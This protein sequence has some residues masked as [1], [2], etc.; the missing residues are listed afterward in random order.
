MRKLTN[1]KR[2]FN[3]IE[4]VIGDLGLDLHGINVLTEAA[5]GP[6]VVTPI[7]AALAGASNVVACTRDSIYGTF[8][9]IS[10][11]TQTL[12]SDYGVTGEIQ[13]TSEFPKVYASEAHLVTNSGFLRPIDEEFISLLPKYAAI[14]LMWETWEFRKG[15][16][17]L[18][19]CEKYSVPVLG[20]CETHPKLEIFRY[21][22][23]TVLKLLLEREIE[24][25]KANILLVGSGHFGRETT[26]VLKANG[27]N[28]LHLEP[29][30]SWSEK[31]SNCKDFL[32]NADAVVL[33][34]HECPVQL[35]GGR[36]GL[37]LEWIKEKNVDI[38]H[39]C[40][41][42]D[43]Q[44]LKD[45][46][47]LLYP[48]KEVPFGVMTVAT[49]YVGPKPVIDLHAAG[50]KVGELLV[51]GMRK[52]QNV[53]EAENDALQNSLVMGWGKGINAK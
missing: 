35:L 21:V 39:I 19:A 50:L 41:N 43:Y 34:E 6:F 32:A 9:E 16:V 22:G 52:F 12:A 25:F 29:N 17:D 1:P 47:I 40:G 48:N 53:R 18:S 31:T 15:D 28:V 46:G 33:V 27:A 20:T 30:E 44:E 37:P 45:E 4:R 26:F 42:V 23:L 5:T 11:Y 51:K 7:I 10:E 38:I 49:D 14:S 24:V 8:K 36:S 3:L 13:I 2:V